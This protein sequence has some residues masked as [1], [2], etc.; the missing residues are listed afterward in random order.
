[1]IECVPPGW[2][3]QFQKGGVALEASLLLS[4]CQL[5]TSNL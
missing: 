3:E 1:M 5:I 2:I 4:M